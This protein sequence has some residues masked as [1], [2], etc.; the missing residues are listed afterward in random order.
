MNVVWLVE[1]ILLCVDVET[2]ARLRKNAVRWTV[3][4]EAFEKRGP[5][6]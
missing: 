5:K 3:R 6:K 2:R 4:F 1:G